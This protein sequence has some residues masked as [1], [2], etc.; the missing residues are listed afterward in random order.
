[1]ANNNEIKLVI[2]GNADRLAAELKRAEGDLARFSKSGTAMATGMKAAWGTI[3]AGIGALGFGAI[4]KDVALAAARYETLGVSMGVVGN[5]A[6]YTRAEMDGFTASLQKNGIA[7]TESREVL[8]RMASAN[9]DLSKASDLARIAQDAAVIGNIN[10]SES[11]AKMIHGIQSGQTDV[12]RTIGINVNFENSY[13]KL[14]AQLGKTTESLTEQEKMQARVNVVMKAGEEIAGT[15]EAAMGT[16]NK[17]LLSSQRYLDN[18][19]VTGGS[20][21]NDILIVGVAGFTG[22]LKEANEQ[23]SL[24]AANGTLQIWGKGL[25]YTFTVLAD[26]IAM[27]FKVVATLTEGLIA[28]GFAV[29]KF[30]DM[31]E[32]AT[33]G[34]Y[35]QAKQNWEELKDIDRQYAQSNGNRW[36]NAG[37][38]FTAGA[39]EMYSSR[40]SNA[41]KDAAA[42]A[43]SEKKRI[44]EGKAAREQATADEKALVALKEKQDA[45]KKAASHARSLVEEWGRVN[46][47]LADETGAVALTGLDHA[48]AEIDKKA[49]K[50]RRK[51]GDK[52][53]IDAWQAAAQNAKIQ[54]VEQENLNKQLDAQAQ[55]IEDVIGWTEEL[56][57][58]TLSKDE[59]AIRGIQKEYE[60]LLNKSHLLTLMGKQTEEEEARFSAA[61][62]VRMGQDLE[63]IKDKTNDLG[64]FQKKA[65]QNMQDAG[66]GFFESLRTGSDNWLDNFTEMTLKMVDQWA[67][68]QMM[69]GLV[70]EDFGTGGQLGGLAG[71]MAGSW[72]DS[73][74]VLGGLHMMLANVYHDGGMVG[75]AAPS[76]AVSPALFVQAPRFH[77]GLAADEFPAILQ[78]GEAVISRK[79]VRA[80]GAQTSSAPASDSAPINITIIAADAQSITEMMRRNPQAVLG[81]LR[82]A[83]QKGDRGLRS[84]L[85]R[86]M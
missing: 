53:E 19:G 8:T 68:A 63:D 30:F 43:A 2:G 79:Q 36:K 24:L 78:R 12:L 67:A 14:A 55:A 85:Q 62:K 61:L 5:N 60:L 52:P 84:D 31:V 73:S 76:R 51:F 26:T 77:S 83:L 56:E 4:I 71:S 1:M 28:S 86:V 42:A 57:T 37:G 17:Q 49:D 65:F 25:T 32:H 38:D 75:G 46:Q 74:S 33:S 41:G 10:S 11:F 15:Y 82:E 39:E 81:P 70:G 27:P 66:A 44:A 40:N 54:A 72:N 20:V 16:A 35:A 50:L 18:L 80:A 45:A 7:M 34:K 23:A 6:G 22:G 47:E 21:F 29:I 3:A 59:K 13:K 58:A 48:L 69:M 9:I 64:E